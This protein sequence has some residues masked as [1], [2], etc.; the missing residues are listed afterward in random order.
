MECQYA[1]T[2]P[3]GYDPQGAWAQY[4]IGWWTAAEGGAGEDLDRA[5]Q[6]GDASDRAVPAALGQIAAVEIRRVDTGET[7]MRAGR[8]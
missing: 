4:S 5:P 6:Q 7:V 3:N 1:P 8:V 2:D